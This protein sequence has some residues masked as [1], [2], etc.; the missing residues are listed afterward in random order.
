MG[1]GNVQHIDQII[2]SL[3]NQKLSVLSQHQLGGVTIIRQLSEGWG[4]Y[5]TEVPQ[6]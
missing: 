4:A 6:S 5:E 2:I 3:L 1:G